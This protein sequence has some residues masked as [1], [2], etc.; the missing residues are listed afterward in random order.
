MI[1]TRLDPARIA[2]ANAPLQK[3]HAEGLAALARQLSRRGLSMEKVLRLAA[4]F[5]VAVPSWGFQQGGTRFGEV[6]K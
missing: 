5:S 2:Q 4:N 3:D 6:R 1:M